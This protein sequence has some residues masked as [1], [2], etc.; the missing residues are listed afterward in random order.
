MCFQYAGIL[1][2]NFTRIK[3]A[4]SHENGYITHEGPIVRLSLRF[5]LGKKVGG[6][7]F[8]TVRGSKTI[9]ESSVVT[10]DLPT[11]SATGKA[12]TGPG[13]SGW[14]ATA[15]STLTLASTG[16]ASSKPIASASNNNHLNGR[17]V[18]DTVIVTFNGD[19]V[20]WVN[21]YDGRALTTS[22]VDAASCESNQKTV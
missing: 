21:N 1:L 12:Y 4:P 20:S 10:H 2:H 16:L 18:A 13:F 22:P 5:A 17:D 3:G 6:T 14:N 19:V 7:T 9:T 8:I 15:F 11:V